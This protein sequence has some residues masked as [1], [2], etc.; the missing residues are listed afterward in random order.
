VCLLALEQDSKTVLFERHLQH[1]TTSADPRLSLNQQLFCSAFA[2]ERLVVFTTGIENSR[3]PGR[4]VFLDSR[5]PDPAR[6]E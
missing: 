5:V 1:Y 3:G 6:H 4:R 2:H